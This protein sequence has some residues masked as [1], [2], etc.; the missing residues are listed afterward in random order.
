MSKRPELQIVNGAL[1]GKRFSVTSG[2]LRLGRS[3]SND[4]HVPDEELSRNH[5]LFEAVGENAIRVTDLASANGTLLNGKPLAGDPVEL[6][7]GDLIE[8]GQTILRVVGD[9]PV[10]KPGAVDLGLSPKAETPTRRRSPLSGIL[11]AVAI[12]AAL[13]AIYVTVLAP[14]IKPQSAV[15]EIR[16]EEPQLRE[17]FYEKVEADSEGI[18][19]FELTLSP[20]GI[21]RVSV[22]DVPKADRNIPM[23]QKPLTE[24]QRATLNEILAFKT[25]RGIDREY[26]GSDPE[27]P[28]LK[29]YRLQ[30]VYSSRARSIRVVN[31]QEPD[32]FRQLREK[33]E[34]FAKN[35][36]GIWAMQYSRDKL[37]ELAQQSLDLAL[38]R[39]QDR[40]VQNGNLFAAVTAYK[41]A[42]FYLETVNPKPECYEQ[43]RSGCERAIAELDQRY[44]D[45]RFLANR[46]INLAQW[47]TAQRELIALLE[48]IPDRN[49][50]RHREATSKLVDVEKRLKGGK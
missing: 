6:K 3:S 13:A 9:E 31:T 24:A 19:R 23:K 33:L 2:G 34:A 8:V 48:L 16:E 25:I 49:D 39:W 45:R 37:V 12:L 35:E 22:D 4:I 5:C 36:L 11:W 15:Q 41:E 50:D 17:L 27:P 14:P 42:M 32:S 44:A 21:I 30:V 28:A 10:V 40:D 47:E 20:D 7:V 26:V 43:A 38:T 1:A 29:S 46:A 18:F